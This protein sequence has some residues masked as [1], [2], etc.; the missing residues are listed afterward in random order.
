MS[1]KELS[2][3]ELEAI[4]GEPSQP[5]IS[6]I[7]DI[8]YF[9]EEPYILDNGNSIDDPEQALIMK[10]IMEIDPL[11]DKFTYQLN[12]KGIVNVCAMV[13][14]P[15][16]L[17]CKDNM[18]YYHYDGIK[19]CLDKG[20]LKTS[21]LLKII[22]TFLG[23]IYPKEKGLGDDEAKE[24]FK[25]IS[26]YDSKRQRDQVMKDLQDELAVDSSEFNKNP[27]LINLQNVT[28]DLKTMSY[29]YH[30]S[31]DM[32]TMVTNCYFPL[33]ESQRECCER[34][35][36]FFNQ[37]MSK[38]KKKARFLQECLGYSLLGINPKECMF[39]AYGKTTRNGKSTLFDTITEIM[40]DYG[41]NTNS[42]FLNKSTS[43]NDVDKPSPTVVSLKDKRFINLQESDRHATFD[44]A[45]IKQI[46]G[47][48]KIQGRNLHESL[49]EFKI[50]GKMWF[51][52]NHLPFTEDKTLFTSDRLVVFEFNEH[53][54][55]TQRD[56]TL[57]QLFLQDDNKAC[58]FFFLVEGYQ[59]YLENNLKRPTVVLEAIER[60]RLACNSVE[61]FIVTNYIDTKDNK[62][63]VERKALFEKYV[64]W[65]GAED[66][67]SVKKQ[68]F[69]EEIE[70]LNFKM[71]II[72]GT[73]YIGGL[74]P[75]E[76]SK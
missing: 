51:S 6:K 58:I 10:N 68:R 36:Q 50:G 65:C 39:I 1:E 54:S 37:I 32:L 74:K 40:G 46:T 31:K 75:K 22:F 2:I 69:N 21:N 67:T 41:V 71:I 19:W 24:Y 60:Y 73:R 12:D 64:S 72:H 62:D 38:D 30:D 5:L 28:F 35:Y 52:C 11:N 15:I 76:V 47:N 56:D 45:L 3:E 13:L 9:E 48:D 8:P 70:A 43:K 16:V 17:F 42:R 44:G 25:Y 34:F 49:N 29:H 57:K 61:R 23:S 27:Y 14:K 4:L 63:R 18:K 53:F 7:P 55:A 66:I 20:N 26:H 33:S 59:L